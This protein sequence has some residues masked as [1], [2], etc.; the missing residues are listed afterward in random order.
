MGSNP[1]ANGVELLQ[2][3]SMP[4]FVIVAGLAT[5]TSAAERWISYFWPLCQHL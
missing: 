3:L 2:L 5:S 4:H 1:H